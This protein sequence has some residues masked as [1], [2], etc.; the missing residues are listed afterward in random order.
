MEIIASQPRMKYY[1]EPFNI[2]RDDVRRAG[3]FT[4]WPSLMPDSGQ[5]ESALSYL[6]GLARN[7]FP[8]MNPPPF[9]KYHRLLTS[10]IVFKIL[11]MEHMIDEIKSR[12]AG[13]VVYLIRH[14]LAT[15]ISR[16]VLPRLDLFVESAFYRDRYLSPRQAEEIRRLHEKGTPLQRAVLSWC[17]ENLIPLKHSPRED[18]LLLSYEEL[19]LNTRECCAL[20]QNRLGLED[21]GLMLKAAGEP[22]ANIYLSTDDTRRIMA[23][24]DEARK[25]RTLITKWRDRVT[26]EE[27]ASAF[28]V[29]ALFELDPYEPE[30]FMP[31][32]RYLHHATAAF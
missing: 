28:E 6:D 18:W 21:L 22:A 2:R 24:P 12:C 26:P 19:L 14:P 25:K 3:V 17:F 8:H 32:A 9:G 30:R 23:D 29:L 5:G 27:E 4:S 1:D 31:T 16:K 11:A 7:R 20:V 10:R 13:Q 15:S